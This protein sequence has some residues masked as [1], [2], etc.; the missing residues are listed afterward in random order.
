MDLVVFVLPVL[1]G[2]HVQCSSVWENEAIGRLQRVRVRGLGNAVCKLH[3]LG[4]F[5][6]PLCPRPGLS[7]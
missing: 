7:Y 1:N 3:Q 5:I 4:L 6:H 2:R